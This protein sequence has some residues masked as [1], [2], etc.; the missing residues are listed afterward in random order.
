MTMTALAPR[1]DFDPI[2]DLV[3]KGLTSKH[4]RRA[5][6]RGLTDFLT[7]WTGQGKPQMSKAVVQRYKVDLQDADL[8]PSTI[9]QRLT[10]IRALLQEAA[11]NGLV[12]PH[13]AAGIARVKG[14]TNGGVRLGNWLSKEQAQEL[15]NAPNTK[16][17]KGLRDRA[18][19]AVLLGTGL[20]RFECAGLTFAHV[21][22]REGRWVIVNLVGK[23]NKVRSVPLPSWAKTAIDA[24]ANAARVSEGVVFRSVLKS[25]KVNGAS[26]TPQA[27]YDVV[28]FHSGG[29]VVAHDTRRTYAKLAYL[30]GAPL[31]QIQL[32]LGHASVQTTERY[33]GIEQ[34]LCNAPCDVLG[35]HL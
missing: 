10:A 22:Q 26:M 23:R 9:N 24:W 32:S 30:G 34:D 29:D 1:T 21:Q 3:E 31:K 5:Y 15:L 20:R 13:L 16:T 7:W 18:I 25:D 14:V 4:S 19:L 6:R 35:L 27:I 17:L 28:K 2:V 33:L 11:D 8:S 12:D